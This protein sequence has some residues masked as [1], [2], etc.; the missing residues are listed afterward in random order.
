[1][2][3]LNFWCLLMFVGA[4]IFQKIFGGGGLAFRDDFSVPVRGLMSVRSQMRGELV[5]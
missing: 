2:Q 4:G 5:R 3:E 1:M